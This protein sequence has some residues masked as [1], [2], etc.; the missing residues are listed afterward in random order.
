[1]IPPEWLDQAARRLQGQIEQAPLTY[2]PELKLYLKGENRQR[3]G[4]FKI[5][6]ALNKILALEPWELKHGLVPTSPGN[7][8]FDSVLLSTSGNEGS[9]G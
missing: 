9:Q 6:G 4:S 3:T 5:R 7:H 2:D 1:M 8:I